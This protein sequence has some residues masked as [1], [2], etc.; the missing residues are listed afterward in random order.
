M[1][2]D[3]RQVVVEWLS[4]RRSGNWKRRKS[5]IAMMIG[6]RPRPS[7]SEIQSLDMQCSGETNIFHYAIP[8]TLS[9]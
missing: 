7:G 5:S 4:V 3:G 9:Q 1:G 2:A 6:E 8:G